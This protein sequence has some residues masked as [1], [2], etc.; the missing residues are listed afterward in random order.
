MIRAFFILIKKGGRMNNNHYVAWAVVLLCVW[1][2]PISATVIPSYK[3]TPDQCRHFKYVG[4]LPYFRM[5]GDC[6]VAL[7]KAPKGNI[8]SALE[9]ASANGEKCIAQ[10]AA[11]IFFP[12]QQHKNIRTGTV[13]WHSPKHMATMIFRGP[14]SRSYLLTMGEDRCMY[15]VDVQRLASLKKLQFHPMIIVKIED[16]VRAIAPARINDIYEEIKVADLHGD[17][18]PIPEQFAR[19]LSRGDNWNFLS[20]FACE[21]CK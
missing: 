7:Y 13:D 4:V 1:S 5:N 15:M 12:M 9:G 8:Y 16:L 18:F 6:C 2:N 17:L 3:I 21:D 20:N 14:W 10:A 19:S 11:R